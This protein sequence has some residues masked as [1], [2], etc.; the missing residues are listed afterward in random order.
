MVPQ[1]SNTGAGSPPRPASATM[2]HPGVAMARNASQ[3][4]PGSRNH[5]P[6]VAN[7]PSMA[8]AMPG[9]QP[10]QTP[11]MQPGSPA[12]GMA[13]NTPNN[14]M[15]QG[16]GQM[17]PNMTPEQAAMLQAQRALSHGQ[18]Q[19]G[20]VSH[21]TPQAIQVAQQ[22]ARC[23]QLRMQTNQ[24]YAHYQSIGDTQ[25]AQQ[26]RQRMVMLTNQF[27]Q[28]Q[29]RQAMISSAG[30]PGVGMQQQTSQMGHAHPGQQGQQQ[31]QQGQMQGNMQDQNMSV[32][33]QQALAQQQFAAQQRNGHAQ[34]AAL[35]QRYQGN[36]PAQVVEAL[37]PPL[38]QL[39]HQ[40]QMKQQAARAQAQARMQQNQHPQHQQ[41][42]Q[43]GGGMGNEQY[44]QNLQRMQS[45]L[46]MQMNQ[47]QQQQ[48]MNNGMGMM[49]M[50]NMQQFGGQQ[51]Q[52]GQGQDPLNA[53]FGA[54]QNAL[55][56]GQQGMQ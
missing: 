39:L 12:V 4:A 10:S 3:Q 45:Q 15:M 33:Q 47:P 13:Q 17:N 22:I 21:M 8:Q 49:G 28:L 46:G 43:G 51:Q 38:K 20:D 56:R 44:V 37:P 9:R 40:Q 29:Q 24:N 18:G 14:L 1:G 23:N 19:A 27:K 42:Q 31:G 54:M 7:T 2:Q 41:Q 35:S 26:E 48:P 11:R 6:Q 55:Q 5:T 36:I 34:L 30:S 16:A 52:Q 32:A 25:R 53:H 50:N